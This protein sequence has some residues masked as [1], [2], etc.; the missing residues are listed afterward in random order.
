MSMLAWLTVDSLPS[1]TKTIAFT[2]PDDQAWLALLRGALI[3]LTYPEYYEQL[4]NLTPDDMADYW[5]PIILNF[6]EEIPMFV[7]GTILPF[8]NLVGP[9]EDWLLCDG[10]LV[11][12]AIYPDLF[13]AI[14]YLFGQP[15][16]QDYFYLPDLSSRFLV[17]YDQGNTDYNV[18]GKVGGQDTV[19]LTTNQIP[20]HSHTQNSHNHTQNSHGH[21]QDAHN[22][23]QDAHSHVV[24]GVNV[25]GSG[26][27]NRILQ[28]A[29]S[30]SNVNSQAT[31]A[32]NNTATATNQATTAT[33]QA[34]TATNQNTGGGLSHENRP[35][36][37]TL[38]YFIKT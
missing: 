16:N 24:Y 37:I 9:G 35:P 36:F 27:T 11:L 13:D 31:T 2:V 20:A 15:G 34:A 18:P 32:T 6:F 3:P 38:A 19:T 5:R 23:S 14:G 30:S 21:V 22:H 1:T 4:G 33:N 25:G 10:S 26:G 29:S 28:G 7:P 8:A 12:K 17:G